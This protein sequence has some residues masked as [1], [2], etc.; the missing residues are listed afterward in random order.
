MANA[1]T[2]PPPPPEIPRLSAVEHLAP[3][4]RAALLQ[5]LDELRTEHWPPLVFET[6]RTDARQAYLWGF[7]RTYS[8]G[9]GIVTYSRDADETWH[10]FGLA[11]DVVHARAYWQAPHE[12][13]TALGAAARRCG[14]TW[15]G[16]WPGFTDR[17]HLQWGA[18]T[19]RSPSPRAARLRESGG[20]PAVWAE[21]G[22]L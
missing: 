21:V 2:L 3:R 9:R 13:W 12:F 20:L 16:D 22:A 7:G 10:G 14:L 17:P 15:G 1:V 6:L 5:V 8:D 18:P 4:F 19:R 11:A